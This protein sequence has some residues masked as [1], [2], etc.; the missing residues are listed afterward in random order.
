MAMDFASIFS[1]EQAKVFLDKGMAEQ[2]D[3][4]GI[5][6]ASVHGD[7]AMSRGEALELLNNGELQVVFSVDLFSEG[8]DLPSIDTVLLLRPT[9]SKILFL[10]Q[11]GRGR[12]KSEEK[13]RLII[14]DFVGNRLP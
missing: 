10:Q 9:E 4:A 14:L 7:S 11:M 2:F 6:A 1:A 5:P 13:D 12:R 3:K 8:V